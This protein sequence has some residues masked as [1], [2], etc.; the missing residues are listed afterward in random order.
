[1]Q[2]AREAFLAKHPDVPRRLA[3]LGRAIEHEQE[4]QRG[5][6]Y[7]RIL[8]REQA[9]HPRIWQ[10]RRH[11]P[12]DRNVMLNPQCC[13]SGP[14]RLPPASNSPPAKTPAS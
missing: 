13:A 10:R 3:E 5:Q 12:G 2:Q 8:Q 7:K 6:S 9:R 1:M 4:V 11:R 14:R